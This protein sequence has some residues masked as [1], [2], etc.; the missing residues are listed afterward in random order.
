[1]SFDLCGW[2]D[3][4]PSDPAIQFRS[5]FLASGCDNTDDPNLFSIFGTSFCK[6]CNGRLSAAPPMYPSPNQEDTIAFESTQELYDAVDKYLDDPS[7]M[8]EVAVMYGF[9]IRYWN[10]SLIVDFSRVFD[11]SRN[12]KAAEFNQELWWDT[13]RGELFDRM[14]AGAFAFDQ[15]LT[16]FDT[17]NAVSMTEMCTLPL[18]F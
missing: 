6:D 17:R 8:S 10:T 3:L 13:Q 9:P 16:T 1:M 2:K 14:F 4:L 12:P 18:L 15:N 7:G 5:M 11:A